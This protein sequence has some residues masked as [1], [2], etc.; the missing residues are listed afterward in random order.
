MNPKVKPP[1]NIR[2]LAPI[3]LKRIAEKR[4]AT[5]ELVNKLMETQPTEHEVWSRLFK[6]QGTDIVPENLPKDIAARRLLENPEEYSPT[7]IRN[8]PNPPPT[9]WFRMTEEG[10]EYK[11]ITFEKPEIVSRLRD[12]FIE[13]VNEALANYLVSNPAT[14][15]V[16]YREIRDAIASGGTKAEAVKKE[17]ADAV[18]QAVIED[19]Y[20]MAAKEVAPPKV[21]LKEYVGRIARQAPKHISQYSDNP[22]K[23]VKAI[24]EWVASEPEK[25]KRFPQVYN[26]GRRIIETIE[27]LE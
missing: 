16:G 3:I 5:K 10:P 11:R 7:L 1:I 13:N 19:S 15:S 12:P 22:R 27:E 21:S 2:D 18:K 25:A 8:L 20:F 23:A 17:L 14:Q 9:K 6:I 4:L 26:F 24:V